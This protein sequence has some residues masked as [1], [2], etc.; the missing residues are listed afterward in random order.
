VRLCERLLH[1]DPPTDGEVRQAREWVGRETK[2][3]VA[4]MGN[5]QTA[6]FVGTA[7]TVTS[8]AAMAQKLPTYEPTRIHNYQ[9]QLRTIQDLEQTLLIRKQTDRAGLPGL[10]SG[11]EEVIAAGAIIIRIVME[12]LLMDS[13]LVSDLGLREGVVLHL[14]SQG[15]V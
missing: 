4:D 7:G 5:Y 12:T 10:E 15:Y 13:C 2:A 1:H 6:T 8:L 11:R 14:A 3:A 9:L